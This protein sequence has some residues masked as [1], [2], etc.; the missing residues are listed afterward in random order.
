MFSKS[1]AANKNNNSTPKRLFCL[2]LLTLARFMQ[3][4]TKS[5]RY[6]LAT[7]KCQEASM[8]CICQLCSQLIIYF[9]PPRT[10]N[11]VLLTCYLFFIDLTPRVV[12]ARGKFDKRGPF[13]KIVDVNVSHKTKTNA[14]QTPCMSNRFGQF[15]H[16]PGSPTLLSALLWSVMI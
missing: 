14:K 3:T 2:C 10:S 16:F 4:T 6:D 5:L 15:V 8:K 11:K 13:L 7:L 9:S 1:Q 12:H